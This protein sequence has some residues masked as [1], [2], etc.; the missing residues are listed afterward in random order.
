[1]DRQQLERIF[2]QPDNKS[3]F[4][5]F[6][7]LNHELREEETRWQVREMYRQGVGGFVLHARHGLI[8]PY[9][10]EEWMRN[11]AAAIDEARK[12][13]MKAYLYDE[14][15]WPS[16]PADAKVFEGHP[17]YRMSAVFLRARED[18][19]GGAIELAFELDPNLEQPVAA[20]AVPVDDEGSPVGFPQSA[21]LL[22][23]GLEGN[24]LSTEL[25]EG[26]WRIY[27]FVRRIYVGGFFG[28]YLDTLNPDAV[29]RFIELTHEKY[30]ERFGEDFGATIEGIFTD[31]PSMNRSP[32]D[33]VPWTA[34]LPGEFEFRK[35]YSLLTALPALF[36]NMGP[37]TAKVRCDFYDVASD[38]YVSA[39]FKQIHEWCDGHR[40]KLM[41]HPMYEG[42]LVNHTREQGEWFRVM[43]YMHWG[44]VD[45]LC[46]VTWPQGKGL[47]NLAGPKL[48]S[49]A[50]HLLGKER[51]GCECFG[52]ASQ[53][54]IDLRNLKW[55]ADWLAS[56]GVNVMIPHAFY[57]SIQGFRKWECPPGEFY[58]SPFWPFYKVLADHAGRLCA[59]LNDGH[60]VAD[61][62]FLYPIRS[63]WAALEPA[64]SELAEY[65]RSHFDMLGEALLRLN[66]DFDFVSEEMIQSACVEDGQ[67]VIVGDD[68]TER[69][70]F[71]ALVLPSVTVLSR[72]TAEAL[73]RLVRE[74]ANIL[75]TGR[76]PAES[77]DEGIDP[78]LQRQL[79]SIFG[80]DYDQAVQF[81][82]AEKPLVPS[83]VAAP[84]A[85]WIGLPPRVDD[86][87]LSALS[88]ALGAR[89]RQD[90]RIA[91]ADTG[92]PA[93][94]V[95]HYHWRRGGIDFYVIHNTSRERGYSVA[96][97]LSARGEVSVWDP[98][99]GDVRLAPIAEATDS[100]VRLQLEL[101]P[102]ETLVVGVD[103][104]RP[105]PGT[106]VVAAD[107][108]VVR[109]GDGEAEV[110]ADKPGQYT[111]SVARGGSV[112][113][114]RV[115][116]RSVP[117]PIELS[118]RWSFH[119]E[120]PNALPLVDWRMR[121]ANRVSGRD[122][123]E[124]SL[125]F[126]AQ[127]DAE[128][129]P[130][131]A[132]L[133]LDGLATEKVWQRTAPVAFQVRVNGQ[134]IQAWEQGE[135]LDHYI[136]EAD[137][138]ELLREGRNAI[139]VQTWTHLYEMPAVRYPLILVGRFALAGRRHRL[140]K[141]PGEIGSGGWDA[142]GYPFYSGI[143]RYAQRVRLP[144]LATGV[145]AVLQFERIGDQAQVVVNGKPCGII[146]WEPLEVDITDAVKS[147]DNEIVVR[148]ANSLQNLLVQ[149][150][151][152][153]GILGPVRIVFRRHATV[154][155]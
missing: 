77:S 147:G 20:V 126:T 73:A 68:G 111:L 113:Q 9:M 97:E 119:T 50:S 109:V 93:T 4:A 63:M 64:T 25:P 83:D 90:C 85:A 51:T 71:K 41:G 44:G 56:L 112:E 23:D 116:V 79:R 55:L 17:E 95:V 45:Q 132:R 118:E 7:F 28:G 81:I 38:M 100:G 129:V 138:A 80:A 87:V 59:L 117:E 135:Y 29:R 32:G 154:R 134:P 2:K 19:D 120:K 70:R 75:A 57:Y 21:V 60:H 67:I 37:I 149:E 155:L 123:D 122:Q 99:T 16:G 144:R 10:G 26:R 62:A 58:Q 105:A 133:L 40:I 104:S 153:S 48:A 103:P 30:A 143:A 43:R 35:G 15:N 33:N 131:Q 27:V 49:S 98:D 3:R 108:A 106:P 84:G 115:R 69:E 94:D 34:R 91:L 47:N 42:E 110:A 107:V 31:E 96:V 52:L 151:K 76:L 39:F 130:E 74:G 54:S 152:P 12:L 18:V 53:W 137:I 11:L 114:V 142:E 148:V 72:R 36:E 139:E 46:E 136:V 1:M 5:P 92:Q 128:I 146:A 124:A 141:E 66:Y 6:W 8:T 78:E 150:P 101:P 82:D 88:E 140:V 102:V 22:N 89:I 13:G 86:A 24:L 65:L 14:N 61:V 127:F 125:L 121:M 145:R